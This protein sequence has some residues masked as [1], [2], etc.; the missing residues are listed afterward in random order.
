MSEH[1][2]ELGDRLQQLRQARGESLR[3]AAAGIGCTKTHLH[4]LERG[5]SANPSLSLLR[6]LAAHYGVTVA[7]I[8]GDAP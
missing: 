3:Q 8:I 1:R 7:Q 4:E 6:G 5:V 2:S